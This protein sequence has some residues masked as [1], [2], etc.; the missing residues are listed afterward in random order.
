MQERLIA[1]WNAFA[2]LLECW[3]AYQKA[4]SDDLKIT[5]FTVS[6]HGVPATAVMVAH[7]RSAWQVSDFAARYFGEHG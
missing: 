6:R 5:Y 3:R 4:K 1:S 7:G 2:F